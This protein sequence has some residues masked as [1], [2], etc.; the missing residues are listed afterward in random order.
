MLFEIH[1]G[2]EHTFMY[3]PSPYVFQTKIQNVQ[4]VFETK[5]KNVKKGK[6]CL[7]YIGAMNIHSC[8]FLAP[9]YFKLKY[10]MSKCTSN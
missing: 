9:I 2:D 3:N 10:K 5:I 6:Y 4:N 1:R 7:K 8:M